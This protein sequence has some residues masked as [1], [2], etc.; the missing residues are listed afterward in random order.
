M[1]AANWNCCNSPVCTSQLAAAWALAGWDSIVSKDQKSSDARKA[2]IP[3]KFWCQQNP[4]TRK[5][6][7]PEKL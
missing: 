3:A 6:P 1:L 5:V 4:G 2:L 7:V